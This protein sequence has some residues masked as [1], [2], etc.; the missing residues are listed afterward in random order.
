MERVDV[1]RG[2]AEVDADGN[3]VQGEMRHVAYADGFRG[4]RLETSQSP[5]ADS[6]GVARRYTLYF[7]GPEPTGILDTDCLV[8]RGKPLMVDGP[9]LEWWRHGRHIGDVVNAFVREG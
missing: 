5:G 2:A 1:Y 9:P 3:P 7:R 8:V 4:S 6:Q